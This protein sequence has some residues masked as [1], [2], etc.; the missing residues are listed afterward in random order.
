MQPRKTHF[1]TNAIRVSRG[2]HLPHV[3]HT[4]F[5]I[6]DFLNQP[7]GHPSDWIASLCTTSG[8]QS[9]KVHFLGPFSPVGK[10]PTKKKQ[11]E[12]DLPLLGRCPYPRH[13]TMSCRLP[14]QEV[15][16]GGLRHHFPLAQRQLKRLPTT[17]S[18]LV[19]QCGQC[20]WPAPHPGTA[21]MMPVR[22]LL[23][24][25]CRSCRSPRPSPFLIVILPPRN[26]L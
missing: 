13:Q 21:C 5:L 16:P 12:L 3:D 26:S 2:F 22:R 6:P 20:V 8:A 14:L 23:H 1:G 10:H 15:L 4:F 17:P 24:L 25:V 19:R 9:N 7:P 18:M 11:L